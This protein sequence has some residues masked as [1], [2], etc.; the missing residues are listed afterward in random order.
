MNIMLGLGL[1]L[2]LGIVAVYFIEKVKLPA[3]TGYII[4]GIL[5]GPYV[6]HLMP[7]TLLENSNLIANFVLSIVAFMISRNFA[8]SVFKRTGKQILFVSFL[9]A[10]GAWLF[11]TV[12]I[13]LFLKKPLY[14]AL[15]FGAL[16]AATDPASTLVVSRQYKTRGPV[17]NVLMGTVAIDDAWGLI[18][19]VISMVI[20]IQMK[21][22]SAVHISPF[23]MI[24][25]ALC[26]IVYTLG[27]G[28]IMGFIA[29]SLSHLTQHRPSKLILTLGFILATAGIAMYFH[30][31]PLLACMAL[32]TV[33]VNFVEGE[34]DYFEGIEFFAA[35]LLLILFA[36]VGAGF[37]LKAITTIGAIGSI[38]IVMR[39][40]GKYLGATTGAI[41]S[42]AP[43]SVIKYAGMGLVP[44]AG[45]A[46]GMA[47]LGEQYFP[48]VGQYILTVIIATTLV[49]EIIGPPI[50]KIVFEKAGEVTVKEVKSGENKSKER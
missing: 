13:F 2:I 42:K 49:L 9:E 33:M 24:G 38:Y 3:V 44:Q 28:G 45:V 26:E 22:N 7:K 17:T 4:L 11:V 10:T 46:L 20:A 36:V 50:T 43:K 48:G 31:S 32:G 35:P 30:Y 16:A 39:F 41:L 12:G 25:S 27:I 19:F 8:Y 23:R 5:L 21:G 47:V 1:I 14:V 15:L 37:N 29:V 34:R 6:F 40:I 18:I